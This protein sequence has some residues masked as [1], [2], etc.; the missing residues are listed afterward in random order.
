[1]QPEQEEDA[2]LGEELLRVPFEGD[3]WRERAG[4]K[5]ATEALWSVDPRFRE[6]TEKSVCGLI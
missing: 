5:Q 1:M 3:D 6:G 4:G 2:E